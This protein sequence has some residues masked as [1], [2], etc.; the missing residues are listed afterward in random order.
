MQDKNYVVYHLHSAYSLGDS[1]VNF[2]KYVDKAV[3]L[4]QK[5][6]A[7]T[8]HGNIY[9]WV[10]KKLYCDKK[11]IK[12]IHGM[13]AYLTQG[14]QFGKMADNYHIVLLAKNRA[15][16]EEINSL[17][18]TS[19]QDDHKYYKPRITFDEFLN[20]SDNVILTSACLGGF[21]WKSKRVI[22]KLKEDIT[23]EENLLAQLN[24][25]KNKMIISGKATDK[26]DKEMN[27][28]NE[29]ISVLKENVAYLVKMFPIILNKFDYLEVQ[30]HYKSD[31]QKNYNKEL[32]E[33]SKKY[34][35]PLI[36]GTDT[37][38]IDEYSAECRQILIQD[39]QEGYAY[40]DEFDMVYKTYDELVE[41]FKKQGVLSNKEIN[42]AIE[43]TNKMA[44]MIESFELDTSLKYPNIPGVSDEKVALQKRINQGFAD[45]KNR[46]IID[47]TKTQEYLAQIR[48]E[49]RVFD[50]IG[51]LGFMLFMSNLIQ[52]CREHH[53]PT[54]PCRGSVGGSLIAYIIDIIDV[55]PIKRKT[56]F[57]RFANEDRKEIG[58]I[59]VD[60]SPDQRE[61]VYDYIINSYPTKQT[62]FILS[63][64]SVKSLGVIDMIGR[65]KKIDLNTVAEI[66]KTFKTNDALLKS[67]FPV[68]FD[69]VSEQFGI[70]SDAEI[71]DI[72]KIARK[73]E[74]ADSDIDAIVSY[75]KRN[76]STLRKSYPDIV[77]YYDGLYGVPVSQ[78]VHPAGIIV[79]PDYVD[80]PKQYGVFTCLDKKTGKNKNVL[81]I[82]M[83]CCHEISLVKYDILGLKQVQINRLTCEAAG[84]PSV[85]L[86]HQIDWEDEVVWKHM[87]DSPIGVFQFEG[88]QNCL[89]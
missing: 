31:D 26:I 71:K 74:C 73:K 34:H 72:I 58:D 67:K 43:N 53:I 76:T 32:L 84:L 48:E 17:F 63:F 15:G 60:I 45:K 10:E 19:T 66:K 37:H 40:E 47:A 38:S 51:M 28:K 57:S 85:I 4:N 50:K 33:Y 78:S 27:L 70:G 3:E 54:S 82:D 39:K 22:K 23:K 55:D 11:G 36:A 5:A 83:E 80:L 13:E 12:Y 88:E 25:E 81:S 77:K 7:F 1:V 75:H 61:L 46:G 18:F 65:V 20:I 52:W 49:F 29:K 79:S 41:S 89:R 6:I 16:V 21:V 2:E 35:I 62:A 9:N 24:A 8:E 64:G 30:P 86:S 44:E 56:I 69:G 59:D 14:F 68:V 87:P 42:D